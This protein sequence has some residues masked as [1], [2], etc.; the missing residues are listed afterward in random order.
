MREYLWEGHRI[1]F[2]GTS[3]AP[4]SFFAINVGKYFSILGG[5]ASFPWWFSFVFSFCV[6][7][8]SFFCLFSCGKQSRYSLLI[9]LCSI[10]PI[11]STL[12]FNSSFSNAIRS[13]IITKQTFSFALQTV[14]VILLLN[15]NDGRNYCSTI[16][17]VKV[18]TKYAEVNILK[19]E[20]AIN[21]YHKGCGTM[22][23]PVFASENIDLH[24]RLILKNTSGKILWSHTNY[25]RLR[26]EAH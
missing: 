20:V 15:N 25:M 13:K 5:S 1:S 12:L 21:I 7:F 2:C 6:F 9:S 24:L 4:W 22:G 14:V 18:R 19:K 3:K 16:L 10:V 11:I 26:T 23:V 8:L 17:H